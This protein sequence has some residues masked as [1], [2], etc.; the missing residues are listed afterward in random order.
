MLSAWRMSERDNTS[1]SMWSMRCSLSR[2]LGG[3]DSA[4]FLISICS[5]FLRPELLRSITAT[6]ESLPALLATAGNLYE[7]LDN[8][9]TARY[10]HSAE[11]LAREVAAV[12]AQ[13]GGD[14]AEQHA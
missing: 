14:G 7:G 1:R 8:A 5:A 3:I 12:W 13:Q 10:R 9:L 2:I 6:P 11:P 4:A